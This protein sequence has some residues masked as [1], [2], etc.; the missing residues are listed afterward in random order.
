VGGITVGSAEGPVSLIAVEC[1]RWLKT[2]VFGTGYR[3]YGKKP[4]FFKT[5]DEPGATNPGIVRLLLLEVVLPLRA[6]VIA[7]IRGI[8]TLRKRH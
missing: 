1:G 4:W 7:D 3:R 8:C 5:T 6:Y 2:G